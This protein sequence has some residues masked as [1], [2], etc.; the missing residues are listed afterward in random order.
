L[1]I[2][3]VPYGEYKTEFRTALLRG[4][5]VYDREAHVWEP[6][7][8]VTKQVK[9]ARSTNLHYQ[10]Y[11]GLSERPRHRLRRGDAVYLPREELGDGNYP[12]GV[13]GKLSQPGNPQ[14]EVTLPVQVRCLRCGQVNPIEPFTAD[15]EDRW[16]IDD[17]ADSL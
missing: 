15:P 13:V 17:G 2:G 14:W 7:R 8:R 5:L 1:G 16:A 10:T 4:G 9:K 11:S 6:S 3:G 12:P